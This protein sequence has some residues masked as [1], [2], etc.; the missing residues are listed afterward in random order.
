MI[1]RPVPNWAVVKEGETFLPF[2]QY[3]RPHGIPK[4]VGV[5]MPKEFEPKISAILDTGAKFE[6]EVLNTGQ[7]SF[8]VE[9]EQMNGDV[10]TIAHEICENN[11]KVDAALVRL[12]ESA[13]KLVTAF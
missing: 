12:V 10:D 4:E 8:T 1:A 6:C 9:L 2:T 5:C 7:V 13:Y 11:Q 3:L